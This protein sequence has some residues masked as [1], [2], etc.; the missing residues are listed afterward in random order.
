MDI[1]M[2]LLVYNLARTALEQAPR[3]TRTERTSVEPLR[4]GEVAP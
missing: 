1:G 3:L 2:S 4:P